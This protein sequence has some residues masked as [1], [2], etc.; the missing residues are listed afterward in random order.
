MQRL[1]ILFVCFSFVMSG[2]SHFPTYHC[3]TSD[4]SEIGKIDALRSRPA[5]TIKGHEDAC[6]VNTVKVTDYE[7]GFSSQEKSTP[8]E[9][10]SATRPIT[11]AYVGS[12][13]GFG[14][15]QAIQKRYW[16]KGAIF[17]AGEIAILVS[18]ISPALMLLG[19]LGMK[20]FEVSDLFQEVRDGQSGYPKP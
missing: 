19:F 11:G 12:L 15:G 14:S 5:E 3:Q 2:C 8:I 4:W 16:P 13:V 18:P 20:V 9:A 1:L 6:G 17:T 7:K 10:E